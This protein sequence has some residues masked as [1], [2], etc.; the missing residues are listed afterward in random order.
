ML[1][2]KGNNLQRLIIFKRQKSIANIHLRNCFVYDESR[3]TGNIKE[4]FVTHFL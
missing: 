2:L 1:L 4:S 3:F